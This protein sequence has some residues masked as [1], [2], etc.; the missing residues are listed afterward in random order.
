MVHL[1]MFKCGESLLAAFNLAY[2]EFPNI[3]IELCI[4][5]VSLF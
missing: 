3:T 4:Y 2:C 5:T 1:R